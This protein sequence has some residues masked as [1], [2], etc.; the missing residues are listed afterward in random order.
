LGLEIYAAAFLPAGMI[1]GG[2]AASRLTATYFGLSAAT[3]GNVG[4]LESHTLTTAQLAVHSH[5]V[6]DPGHTHTF[7]LGANVGVV[8]T[9][10]ASNGGNSGNGTTASSAT[11]ISINNAGSG[12]A[13]NNVQ[14][15]IIV[16]YLLFA[17]A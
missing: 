1:W 9:A 2:V 15:T 4:G 14:P 13:H 10:P 3:L 8:Q 12:N 5:G 17:G 7:P 11:G 6:T 16:N